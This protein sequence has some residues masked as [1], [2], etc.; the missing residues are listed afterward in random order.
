MSK[1][2]NAPHAI[3]SSAV[4]SSGRFIPLSS[5]ERNARSEMFQRMLR[6]METITDE[7]DTDGR[8]EKFMQGFDDSHPL[9]PQF[10]GRD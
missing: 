9:R 2:E 7:S 1:Q 5:E 8:W 4:D 10:K 3:S 6:E